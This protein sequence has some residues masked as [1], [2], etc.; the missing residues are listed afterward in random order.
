VPGKGTTFHVYLPQAA[1]ASTAGA[2]LEPTER[3]TQ[4]SGTVIVV[5]DEPMVRALARRALEAYGYT[6][7]EAEDGGEALRVLRTEEGAG[8]ALV[9]ADLV[10]PVMGGRELGI[11]LRESHPG[12]PIL[13]MSAHTGDELARRRLLAPGIWLL[14]KPFTPDEL[15]AQV[16]LRLQ[17]ASRG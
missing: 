17:A 11:R 3:P 4:G 6:V 12:L 16:Q 8:V 1:G 10:M 13:F 9:L 14:Q 7:L 15:V 5:D 2:A